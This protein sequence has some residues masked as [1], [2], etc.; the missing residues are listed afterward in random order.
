MRK[1]QKAVRRTI[2]LRIMML[3]NG[4]QPGEDSIHKDTGIPVI[5]EPLMD[6]CKALGFSPIPE[7]LQGYYAALDSTPDEDALRVFAEVRNRFKGPGPLLPAFLRDI[8]EQLRKPSKVT[9]KSF[10]MPILKEKG[11]T[12]NRLAVESGADRKSIERYLEN[13]T[14][15]HPETRRKLTATLKIE[16]PE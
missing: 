7:Q 11:L 2:Q 1:E 12:V 13:K 10:L 16:L 14:D 8:A 9:R 3:H 4:G 5:D 15:L 6:M